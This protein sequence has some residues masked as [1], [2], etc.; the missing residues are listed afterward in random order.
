MIDRNLSSPGFRTFF[1]SNEQSNCSLLSEIIRVGKK[2]EEINLLEGAM[3]V[4]S[5]AYGK[6]VLINSSTIDLG[7]L[8]REDILEIVDYNPVKKIV[9][10]I[11]QKEPNAET[12]VHWLIHRTRNDVNAIIQLNGEKNLEKISKNLPVTEKEYPPGTFELT[13]EVLKTLKTG[14]RVVIKNR[15][16]LF[17]G[18]SLKEVEDLVL[19]TYE[20]SK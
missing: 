9:L 7:V 1:V 16:I 2:F 6:R 19:K 4:I 18:T 8:K 13:K 5:L 12:P 14:K 3:G 15:G 20:E 11:G 10:A 17:V